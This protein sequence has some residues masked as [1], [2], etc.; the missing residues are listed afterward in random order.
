MNALKS[1]VTSRLQADA[2]LLAILGTATVQVFDKVAKQATKT[3]PIV[4]PYVVFSV[5]T[6]STDY[7][8]HGRAALTVTVQ[9]KVIDEGESSLRAGAADE[10]IMELFHPNEPLAVAGYRTGFQGRI[11]RID[12]TETSSGVKYQHVGGI[13]RITLIPLGLPVSV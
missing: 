4:Y 1:A 7:H 13:Y 8:M 3:E 2:A 10:R 6:D 5:P 12:M 9:V 11:A